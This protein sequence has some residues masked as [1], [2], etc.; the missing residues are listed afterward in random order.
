MKRLI[1]LLLSVLLWTSGWSVYGAESAESAVQAAVDG[2]LLDDCVDFSAVHAHSEGLYTDVTTEEN[3]YAFDDYTMFMRRE[4]AAEWAEYAVPEN[5]YLIFHTYFRQNEEVSHFS[6]SWSADGETW[7]TAEPAIRTLP[8]EEWRW[9][10][11]IYSLKDLDSSAKYVR[12]TFG[13]IG[14]T[15]WS[16]SIAGVYSKYLAE[17]DPG[18]AD[19]IGTPYYDVTALL[20]NLGLIS[21]YNTYEYRPDAPISR[22]EFAKLTAAVLNLNSPSSGQIKR[23][24]RD[25]PK[26]HW[27]GG[28]VYTLH[29]IGVVH[30]DENGYFYPEETILC[31]DAVKILVSALGY[32]V[33][34]EEKG[35]Y[36][37]GFRRIAAEL[38]L[39]SGVSTEPEQTMSR[40]EAAVLLANA[41][42]AEIMKPIGFGEEEN[43]FQKDGSTILSQY[44]RIDKISGILRDVGALSIAGDSLQESDCAVIGEESFQMGAFPLESLLGHEVDAYVRYDDHTAEGTIL[45]AKGCVGERYDEFD[46]N[47][48][49]GIEDNKIVYEQP[50]GR[51]VKRPFSNNT[52]VV[53]N[54]RYDTRM[55]LLDAPE[56]D[57]GFMRLLQYPGSSCVD[58]IFIENFKTYHMASDGRLGERLT[59]KRNGAV[60][61]GLEKAEEVRIFL[62]G[63]ET[64]YTPEI[65]VGENDLVQAAVS[66]DGKAALVH[67]LGKRISGVLSVLDS[68]KDCCKIGEQ[69]VEFS[70]GLDKESLS[71]LLGRTVHAYLDV[72]GKAAVIESG[73]L[74]TQYGYLQGVSQPDSLSSWIQLRI[75]TQSAQAEEYTVNSGTR[76][77]GKKAELSAV[78][79]LSPQLVRFT[80]REDG[81]L[82]KLETA[83]STDGKVGLDGFSLN[84]QSDNSKYYGDGMKLFSSVYQLDADTRVFLI[85][86]D[87]DEI[88]AYRVQDSSCLLTDKS[89]AVRL[90]DVERDFTAGAAVID[91]SGSDGRKLENYDP[92]AVVESVSNI[93]D[94]DGNLC[95]EIYAKVNG[96]DARIYFDAEGGEDVTGSWIPGYQERDTSEGKNP[97]RPGEV[98]QYYM[99]DESHCKYFRMLLTDELIRQGGYESHLG[100]Y[101][102]LTEQ[103]YFSELYAMCGTVTEKFSKKIIARTGENGFLRTFSLDGVNFYRYLS[104]TGKV[105][106]G[107]SSMIAPGSRV[108]VR[109]NFT[110][111]KEILILE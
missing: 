52:R 85:P 43:T 5:Q 40:G 35:G 107:N 72:T 65:A 111:V 59:D 53:Y 83:V 109:M 110:A 70:A 64:D 8:V 16:P 22:A 31:Q 68:G 81:T 29:G 96:Q 89:Y 71:M 73:E 23:I 57:S 80:A 12:I 34:A 47:A 28:A 56:F 49:L 54:G 108:F 79:S 38:E 36:P 41:L 55:G 97:F 50:D 92:V 39:L 26:T 99:D 48:Y 33:L 32:T 58:V 6:F 45:Y 100:D 15:E 76:L 37:T 9:I 11:V 2:I 77:N 98:F 66:R 75:V 60:R 69:E 27:A 18:F 46:R 105:L 91:L 74:V 94:A 24:F 101:G 63:E 87:K 10:P 93:L 51:I 86:E 67:I 106:P 25:L 78:A 20:K 3:R 84:Y 90:Y 4:A 21:G 42:Q 88:K 104:R 14:G 62:Y 30:G 17:G 7:K 1:C 95:L 102:A 82:A 13:N 19:C 44:H 61:L 103:S